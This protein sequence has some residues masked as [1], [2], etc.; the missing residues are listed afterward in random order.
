MIYARLS[1][2][3]SGEETFLA[4]VSPRNIE[5]LKNGE[6]LCTPDKKFLVYYTPDLGW[7]QAQLEILFSKP[8]AGAPLIG[9]HHKVDLRPEDHPDNWMRSLDEI[10]KASLS[11]PENNER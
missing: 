8:A 10:L 3:K 5:K 2:D 1:D 7:V 11:R 9:E 6:P 4:I